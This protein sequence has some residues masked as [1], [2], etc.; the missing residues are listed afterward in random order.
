MKAVTFDRHG[1]VEVLQY[2]DDVPLPKISP[3]EVLIRI[4][5]AAMNYNCLWARNGLPGMDIIF[6]HTNGT[7]GAG[8]VEAIGSEVTNVKVGDEVLVNGGFSCGI[9]YECIRG[10]PMFCPK[11]LIWGFQT[12]PNDGAEGEYAKAPARHVVRKPPGLSFEGAAAVGGVLTTVWR[13]LVTRARIRAGDVVLVWGATGGLGSV[14][15]Q[16]C[17]ALKAKAIGIVG[18]DAKAE[19][20]SQLGADYVINRKTQDIH[21]E[22]LR[23]TGERGV[24]IVLEHSG[25]DSWET[26]MNSLKHGGT[27]V[28]CGATTGFKTPM[29]LRCLWTKQQNYLGSHYG[30]TSEMIDCLRF[31]ESGQIKPVIHDV[32][33]LKDIVR[34]HQILESGDILGK[35]VLIPE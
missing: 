19:L 30:T 21:A 34:G 16:L 5:A 10:E 28:T 17:K 11:F 26:S 32:L 13:M 6:P 1:G 4:K 3:N 29:D 35:V 31:V 7:D 14:A 24:D 20:A 9:C 23:I 2:R 12:G 33:P 25:A 15:I 27:I 22:V 8:V 18:S